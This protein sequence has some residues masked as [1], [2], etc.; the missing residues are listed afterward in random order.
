MTASIFL[1]FFAQIRNY[2]LIGVSKWGWC[3]GRNPP[4]LALSPQYPF[5]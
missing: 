5:F 2:T 4:K 1:S 3:V